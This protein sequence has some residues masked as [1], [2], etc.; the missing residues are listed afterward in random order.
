MLTTLRF[1]LNML[2]G[3][4][5]AAAVYGC[6]LPLRRQRL[7]E[8]G[9]ASSPVR[10]AVLCLFIL[11]VGGMA[12]ITLT[13]PAFDWLTALREGWEKPW[14]SP[15]RVN[16]VPFATF[17]NLYIL[18]GNIIMFLPFGFFPALLFRHFTWRRAL[19]AA[20]CVTLFIEVTQLFVG[21]TF[22]ID[23]LMLNTL[24]AFAG[25]LVQR[26]TRLACLPVS[27]GKEVPRNPT[28]SGK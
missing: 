16:L 5:A 25:F 24:G 18:L 8:K 27:A 6:T 26:C 1:V 9:L 3:M 20:F 2:P 7:R 23:D 11:F 13:P 10:E 22:D 15:G 28:E 14:F 19:L 17:G 21:R 12:A 4:L